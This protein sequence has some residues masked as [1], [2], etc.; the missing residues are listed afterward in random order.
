MEKFLVKQKAT[1]MLILSM[2][3]LPLNGCVYV[4][5]G[6]VGALGGY[7]ASPDTVEGTIV[8]RDYG[9]VWTTAVDVLSQMGMLELQNKAS[10]ILEARLQGTKV[11][12]TVFRVGTNAIKITV[13]AR[14]VFFPK[15]KTAQEIYVKVV[16]ALDGGTWN[17]DWDEDLDK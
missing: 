3:I 13:K 15:I 4:V 8:D 1:W 6:G 2:L 9:S 11:K 7:V 12:I 17:A 5:V 10:G 14:R 16:T